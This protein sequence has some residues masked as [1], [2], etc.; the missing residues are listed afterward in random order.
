M[1]TLFNNPDDLREVA[2]KLR[3]LSVGERA[4]FLAAVEKATRDR[5]CRY[6]RPIGALAVMSAL[7]WLDQ[8]KDPLDVLD[9]WDMAVQLSDT[10]LAIKVPIE[11]LIAALPSKAAG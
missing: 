7:E 2:D 8:D 11:T 4:P 5:K 10:P 9:M 1:V 3:S 6:G